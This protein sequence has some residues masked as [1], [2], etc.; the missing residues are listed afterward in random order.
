[1]QRA[2]NE[3]HV[4]RS[5]RIDVPERHL[6]RGTAQVVIEGRRRAEFDEHLIVGIADCVGI[7]DAGPGGPAIVDLEAGQ[8]VEVARL[9][10]CLSIDRVVNGAEVFATVVARGDGAGHRGAVGNRGI[11]QRAAVADR[12]DTP[13]HEVLID[14]VGRELRIQAGQIE[15]QAIRGPP[16]HGD[17]GARA[18]PL[19]LEQGGTDQ[20]GHLHPLRARGVGFEIAQH[21]DPVAAD[22]ALLADQAGEHTE[23]FIG[24]FPAHQTRQ[25]RV[26]LAG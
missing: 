16:L 19:L 2:E 26:R 11:G 20:R 10:L 4:V 7:T 8:Q 5:A 14:V 15:F 12:A 9:G 25:V 23:G 6:R 22:V 18:D 1:M 21:L 13:G 3:L 17:I 24:I